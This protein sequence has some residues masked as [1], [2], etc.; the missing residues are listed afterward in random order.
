MAIRSLCLMNLF[1]ENSNHDCG[2][3]EYKG[4]SSCSCPYNG[5]F[6]EP[7]SSCLLV[8]FFMFVLLAG[9][10]RHSVDHKYI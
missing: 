10:V 8:H 7:V 2:M 4:F 6:S 9:S 5:Q 1:V 3:C